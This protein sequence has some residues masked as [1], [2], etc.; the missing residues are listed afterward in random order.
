MSSSQY[1]QRLSLSTH[2]QSCR[3]VRVQLF[4]P[5]SE[6]GN[7]SANSIWELETVGN[8]KKRAMRMKK[9]RISWAII[10]RQTTKWEGG[11]PLSREE[12]ATRLNQARLISQLRSTVQHHFFDTASLLVAGYICLPRI[13]EM[14]FHSRLRYDMHLATRIFFLQ[15]FFDN[16]LET[17]A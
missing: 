16:N 8:K 1:T 7:R 3:N 13:L 6:D 2:C 4:I 5:E 14:T 15:S 17:G 12:G 10:R 11:R 9:E